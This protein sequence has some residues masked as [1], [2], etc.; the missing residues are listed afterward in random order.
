VTTGFELYLTLQQY[1]IRKEMTSMANTVKVYEIKD[2]RLTVAESIPPKLLIEVDA[3]VLGAGYA[4][5][6][7]L[8]YIYVQP[9]PDGIYEFDFY[10]TPPSG[11]AADVLSVI[12]AQDRLE[13]VPKDLKGVKVYAS[14]NSKISVLNTSISLSTICLKGKLTDEGVECQAFRSI[15]GELFTLVGNLN[16]FHNGDEVVVCGTIAG[17]SFCMQGTTINVSWIGK[18]APKTL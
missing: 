4:D 18:E 11:P 7:L 10:A 14:H 1:E 5:P 3:I 17:V 6:G 13:P 12:S 16:G 9:P 15:S 8:Q 2:V